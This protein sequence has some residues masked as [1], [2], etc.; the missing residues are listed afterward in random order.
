MNTC[1]VDETNQPEL[2]PADNLNPTRNKVGV[3]ILSKKKYDSKQTLLKLLD[4]I[5]AIIIV[6][7]RKNPGK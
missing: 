4:N 6:T 2:I 3:N 5:T 1:E 7:K